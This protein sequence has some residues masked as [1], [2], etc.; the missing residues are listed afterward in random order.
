M[1]T[2]FVDVRVSFYH[3]LSGG[4]TDGSFSIA[5][6][7]FAGQ[8]H[9]HSDGEEA[10][11]RSGFRTSARTIVSAITHLEQIS[12]APGIDRMYSVPTQP[13]SAQSDH[14][15]GRERSSPGTTL[16]ARPPR[17]CFPPPTPSSHH[18]A[19]TNHRRRCQSRCRCQGLHRPMV[20]LPAPDLRQ[21]NTSAVHDPN[22]RP[23][24]SR[25]GCARPGCLLV[26]CR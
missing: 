22:P 26:H 25:Q 19:P 7:S 17:T 16:A 4:M 3:L 8:L 1:A 18:A 12:R 11:R 2:R 20:Q 23:R 24:T 5:S 13:V 6:H 21:R 15:S 9:P 14:C 10:Q